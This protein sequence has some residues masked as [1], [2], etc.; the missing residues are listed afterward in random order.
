MRVRGRSEPLP[1]SYTRCARSISMSRPLKEGIHLGRLT[2]RKPAASDPSA[3]SGSPTSRTLFLLHLSSISI[4]FSGVAKCFI[5]ALSSLQDATQSV[6][7][8]QQTLSCDQTAPLQLHTVCIFKTRSL[9]FSFQSVSFL[10]RGHRRSR[11]DGGSTSRDYLYSPECQWRPCQLDEP[12]RQIPSKDLAGHRDKTMGT[13]RVLCSIGPELQP[14]IKP[15]HAGF[16]WPEEN[17]PPT[18]PGFS[19]GFLLNLY[20]RWSFGS[21]WLSPLACFLG[22]LD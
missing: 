18:V 19:Q 3:P 7:P 15:R 10:F 9:L 22:T 20:H 4:I 17:C 6:L 13:R 1:P 11:P 21:L 12:Q 5:G 8:R 14:R 2:L 16:V